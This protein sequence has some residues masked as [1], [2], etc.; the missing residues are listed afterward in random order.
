MILLDTHVL[1]WMDQ[2]RAELGA[3]ARRAIARAATGG[4]VGVSAISFWEIAMLCEKGRLRLE[5]PASRWRTDLLG[6]GLV[7]VPV[8]GE[9]SL[10]AAGLAEMHAD[11]ADRFIAATAQLLGA[12]LL[13]ADTRLLEWPGRLKRRD[14]RR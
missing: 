1:V 13:T 5:L 6:A 7:E 2:D 12:T 14:A 8:D 9:V 3:G 10:A 4:E 11:P